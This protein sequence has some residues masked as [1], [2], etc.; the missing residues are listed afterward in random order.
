MES[1]EV[2]GY[3]LGKL[4]IEGKTKQV[5]DVSSNS[6]EFV[7]LTNDRITAGNIVKAYDL[8][9]KSAISTKTTSK[10]LELLNEV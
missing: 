5:Y 6:D 3:K 2:G 4:I 9:G 10:G 7:L 8:A 1:E